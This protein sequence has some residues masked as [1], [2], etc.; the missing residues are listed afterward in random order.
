MPTGHSERNTM[1]NISNQSVL[2]PKPA[3]TIRS[4]DEFVASIP[5]LL[6]FVPTESIVGVCLDANS[7]VACTVRIDLGRSLMDEAERLAEVATTA[8]SDRLIFVVYTGRGS[9]ELPR[10]TQVDQVTRYLRDREIRVQDALLV[11][12]NVFWSYLCRD[13]TC[14][15]QEGRPVPTTPSELEVERVVA[16]APA[17]ASSRDAL[18]DL[19]RPRPELAPPLDLF[20]TQQHVLTWS[21]KERCHQAISDLQLLKSWIVIGDDDAC[22][23]ARAR[24]MLLLGDLMVRD[25][26]LATVAGMK[27][28]QVA[29]AT[30]LITCLALTSPENLRAPVAATAAA[31]TALRG[32]NPVGTWALIDL[33][34]DQHLASLVAFAVEAALPPRCLREM[35]ISTLRIVEDQINA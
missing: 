21:L 25:F 26:L 2:A 20:A 35:V 11:D 22:D 34:E 4:I 9:G 18:R 24:L 3:I 8:D 29:V 7:Q 30:R 28:T 5:A 32:D 12:G 6:G 33:A 13:M 1:N 14:C 27:D 10:S 15:P 16:G 23:E 19:Y 31:L 17:V